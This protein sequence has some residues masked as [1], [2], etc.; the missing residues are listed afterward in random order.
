[1]TRLAAPAAAFVLTLALALVASTQAAPPPDPI[2][3]SF[4]SIV[5]EGTPWADELKAIKARL[6]KDGGGR[7]KVALFL[8]GRRGSEN[9]M[10]VEL[11]RGKL[12][13]V[14]ISTG[15][16]AAEV[17]ELQCLEFPYLLRTPEDVDFILEG[18]IGKKLIARAEEKGMTVATWG[19]N[20]WRSVGTRD[21]AVRKPEDLK[22]LK[23]RAQESKINVEFWK[24][25]GAAPT[26]IPLNEVMSAL[27]TTV[28]DGFDQTPVYMS[29]AG[30]HGEIKHFTLTE[31]SYQGGVV[32]YNKRFL[33][34]LPE[35]L[36]KIVL[37]DAEL[38]G[39]RNRENVRRMAR[40]VEGELERGGI[41][42]HRLTPEEHDAF[43]KRTAVV[44]DKFKDTEAGA[45]VAE[46]R[47]AL[48]ERSQAPPTTPPPGK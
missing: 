34:S 7:V 23:V 17:P 33:D 31:H 13:G 10:L 22:D 12:Q 35:D 1:M 26:Q 15:S 2:R 20:G 21:K 46:I 41:Q 32:V 14:A 45:L 36:R 28:I 39:R 44:Y 43:V 38:Q 6:E 24:A 30:W 18:P 25:M 19:E 9:D 29:A 42:V 47:K 27:K 40:E 4:G 37:A 16:L 8:G 11:R 48:A 3:I 5:P